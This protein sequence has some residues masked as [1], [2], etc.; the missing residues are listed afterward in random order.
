MNRLQHA[1]MIR[2]VRTEYEQVIRVEISRHTESHYKQCIAYLLY[3]VVF[4][5]DQEI[6]SAITLLD[7]QHR[8]VK[9]TA[10]TNYLK[11]LIS[12]DIAGYFPW[13]WHYPHMFKLNS[14]FRLLN[15]P[16]SLV[17]QK[18]S[19]LLNSCYINKDQPKNIGEQLGW[20]DRAWL[21]ENFAIVEFVMILIQ[22]YYIEYETF[23]WIYSE[24]TRDNIYVIANIHFELDC[25]HGFDNPKC[26]RIIP[27]IVSDRPLEGVTLMDYYS[28]FNAGIS[29]LD[30]V[31]QVLLAIPKHYLLERIRYWT[32][33]QK[34]NFFC[35]LITCF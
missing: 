21:V 6:R 26:K 27:R 8:H 14:A 32:D 18:C 11:Q 13:L 28:E 35:P 5:T 29:K 23:Q 4:E 9:R 31:S 20:C 2:D 33:E 24:P 22:G 1:I 17:G 19:H 25:Y 30:L 16:S 7:E 10:D 3:N 12:Y 34:I 15:D